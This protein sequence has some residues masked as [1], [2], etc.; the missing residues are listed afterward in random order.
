MMNVGA[1]MGDLLF[2]LDPEK[3]IINSRPAVNFKRLSGKGE[4]I[5]LATV[6][7]LLLLG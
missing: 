4:V 7:R 2:K 5:V 1:S 6:G 3:P